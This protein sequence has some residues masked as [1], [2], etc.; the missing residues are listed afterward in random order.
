MELL[1]P[2]ALM[3]AFVTGLTGS[4]HCAL[5]CGPLACAGAGGSRSGS[6]IAGWHLGRLFSYALVGAL[7]GAIGRGVS[8][9]L[10]DS[11]QRVLPF[12]MAAGLLLT[13]FDVTKRLGPLPLIGRG[14]RALTSVAAKLA[15]LERS[16]LFGVATP[17]LPC[18]LLYGLFLAAM[19]SAHPLSG[20][21]IMV[22][23]SLGAVPAVVGVQLGAA[24]LA[25]S[26]RW[27]F[28]LRRAVPVAAAV[29]LV[30]RALMARADTVACG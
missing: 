15:P 26:E 28:V 4:V 8:L 30:V 9:A 21:L 1:L 22:V 10:T 5:M 19:A 20:A 23:F 16:F 11:V 12:V 3:S 18:G 27:T 13:A 14:A 29:V 17:L 7:L 24:R 2:A 6:A 25:Q